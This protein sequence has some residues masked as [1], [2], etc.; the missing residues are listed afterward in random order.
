MA[1]PKSVVSMGSDLSD[2]RCFPLDRHVDPYAT[3]L[4]MLYVV[5]PHLAPHL[6]ER[7]ICTKLIGAP[8]KPALG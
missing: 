6:G 7:I 3:R 1:R 2:V 4:S 8:G 5:G